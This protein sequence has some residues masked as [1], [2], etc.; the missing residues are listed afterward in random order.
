MEITELQ[1]VIDAFSFIFS[2]V[3]IIFMAPR[4]SMLEA[5]PII[6]NTNTSG[7]AGAIVATIVV[8]IEYK[9]LD[10]TMILV[11]VDAIAYKK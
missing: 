1:Y 8:S 6:L 11:E 9:K 7:L 4:F 3:L 5:G 2:A 10:I